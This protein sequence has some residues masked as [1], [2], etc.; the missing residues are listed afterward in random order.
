MAKWSKGG[1]STIPPSATRLPLNIRTNDITIRRKNTLQKRFFVCRLR[2]NTPTATVPPHRLRCT[3]LAL[4]RICSLN[5]GTVFTVIP[6]WLNAAT[7]FAT[8]RLTFVHPG[9]DVPR[10]NVLLRTNGQVAI[11]GKTVHPYLKLSD[12]LAVNGAMLNEGG[13]SAYNPASLD[14][15]MFPS[16]PPQ[17]P[18]REHAIT[19]S[20]PVALH[21]AN[22]PNTLRHPV[23]ASRPDARANAPAAPAPP[24]ADDAPAPPAPPS[25]SPTGH[26][27]GAGT[28]NVGGGGAPHGATPNMAGP[29]GGASAAAH[30][31]PPN[32]APLPSRVATLGQYYIPTP[33]ALRDH[34]HGIKFLMPS[35]KGKNADLCRRCSAA[36]TTRQY[37]DLGGSAAD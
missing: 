7:T 27:T 15:N 12:D 16:L 34:D 30:S 3:C 20:V 6:T 8:A 23:S 35:K 9:V 29:S 13:I 28:P 5:R 10:A 24:D 18:S 19:D 11:F 33:Q 25:P 26:A 1:L 2:S 21:P 17:D 31:F 22:A 37:F 4:S 36:T 32:A 14:D